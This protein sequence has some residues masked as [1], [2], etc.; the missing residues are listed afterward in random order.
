MTHTPGPWKTGTGFHGVWP[1]WVMRPTSKLIALTQT[2]GQED[3]DGFEGAANARL[4]AAAPDLL[5]DAE[6]VV[7][8]WELGHNVEDAIAALKATIAKARGEA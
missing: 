5:S 3:A 8:D 7:G 1:V 4:I 2:D 6:W